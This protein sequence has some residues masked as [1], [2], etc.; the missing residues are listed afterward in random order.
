[1]YLDYSRTWKIWDQH[2]EI[3]RW[4]AKRVISRRNHVERDTCDDRS[5]ASPAVAA[6]R[7]TDHHYRSIGI[8][9]REEKEEKS[10][11]CSENGVAVLSHSAHVRSAERDETAR[12]GFR[13][14]SAAAFPRRATVR[15]GVTPE[16]GDPSHSYQEADRCPRE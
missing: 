10:R 4:W 2:R 5:R 7:R 11:N 16:T 8:S 12:L 13:V 15:R 6:S 3:A 14:L 1:M 9:R